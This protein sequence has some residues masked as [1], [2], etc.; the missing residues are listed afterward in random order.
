MRSSLLRG[1]LILSL[2]ALLWAGLEWAAPTGMRQ[3]LFLLWSW[4]TGSSRELSRMDQG[5][6]Y[7]MVLVLLLVLSAYLTTEVGIRLVAAGLL[8][9][10]DWDA[11]W[12][13]P[14]S[15]GRTSLLIGPLVVLLDTCL[16]G[17]DPLLPLLTAISGFSIP[18]VALYYLLKWC[19]LTLLA[20][21][22]AVRLLPRR[23][24]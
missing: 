5:V 11:T 12:L 15:D 17:G 23:W 2:F 21:L 9:D 16:L 14:L 4:G 20:V 7:A 10:E 19:L 24:R 13:L 8:P 1:L 22:L 3:G 6:H 18:V